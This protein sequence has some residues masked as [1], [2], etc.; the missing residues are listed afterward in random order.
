MLR[1]YYATPVIVVVLISNLTFAEEGKAKPQAFQFQGRGNA[2]LLQINFKALSDPEKS[3]WFM[4]SNA[5]AE[6]LQ[7]YA[8]YEVL[9]SDT[10]AVSACDESAYFLKGIRK[11]DKCATPT[12]VQCPEQHGPDG[13]QL[14]QFASTLTIPLTAPLHTASRYIITIQNSNKELLQIPFSNTATLASAA[15]QSK[16]RTE[17]TVTSTMALDVHE[18]QELRVERNL[19]TGPKAS[20]EAYDA[21]V[22]KINESAGIVLTLRPD[23]PGGKANPLSLEVKGLTD[24]YGVPVPAQGKVQSVAVP[25]SG[26]AGSLFPNSVNGAYINTQLSAIAAVGSTPTFAANGAIAPWDPSPR[27]IRLGSSVFFDP[28]VNFDIGNANAKS[29]NSV[30]V[31]A[32]FWTPVIFG[33]NEKERKQMQACA[34]HINSTSECLRDLQNADNRALQAAKIT[35]GPRE[36]F[37]TQYGGTNILGE[38]RLDLYLQALT[39][40]ADKQ[41]AVYAEGNP[42]IRDLLD[43]PTNGF[44]ITPYLLFDGGSHIN[45][46]T[47]SNT[48][49][50]PSVTVPTYGISRLYG[51]LQASAQYGRN[52][53]S[54]DGSY[55]YLFLPETASFSLNKVNYIHT[56]SGFLPHAKLKY[57]FYLDDTKHFAG[58]IVWE[59]GAAPPSWQYLN[60]VSVGLQVTY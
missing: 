54:I 17:V 28:A 6:Q 31:P 30:V 27:V 18:D 16:L 26:T 43:L 45:S 55:V 46:Q 15:D 8:I 14:D 20:T 56:V 35:F 19:A 39:H 12:T 57:S 5:P 36:E 49:P 11:P 10:I 53:V 22:A 59:N 51:G 50:N 44:M 34:Q 41:A 9:N 4:G 25:Q 37:D 60:K 40:T 38:A 1:S 32:P 42:A 3:T 47:I 7:N 24:F 21:K 23:L 58:T 48:K 33:W 2:C 52:T 29:T 13:P